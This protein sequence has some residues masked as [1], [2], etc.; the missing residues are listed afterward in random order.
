MTGTQPAIEAGGNAKEWRLN[1]PLRECERDRRMPVRREGEGAP[2]VASAGEMA[3]AGRRQCAPLRT[4]CASPVGSPP[5]LSFASVAFL[6][7]EAGGGERRQSAAFCRPE[8]T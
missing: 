2:V 6:R 3:A 4:E 7:V 8:T 1:V 5:R